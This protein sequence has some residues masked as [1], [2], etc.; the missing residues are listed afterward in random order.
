MT[1]SVDKVVENI[2]ISNLSSGRIKKFR[3]EILN[4]I[5]RALLLNWSFDF[6]F[7]LLLFTPCLNV[8]KKVV[9][10]YVLH[11]DSF[12]WKYWSFT[13]CYD[14]IKQKVITQ[15]KDYHRVKAYTP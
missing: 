3:L 10:S 14:E 12:D 5:L 7:E 13:V 15:A 11:L 8:L 1:N 2:K 4:M 9:T 6:L